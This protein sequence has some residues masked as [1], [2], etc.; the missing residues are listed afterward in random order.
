MDVKCI[1][2]NSF[3]QYMAY[4]QFF[5]YFFQKWL[6]VS[7]KRRTGPPS[8]ELC[9]Y[10]YLR[11]KKFV[12]RKIHSNDV[13]VWIGS[14]VSEFRAFPDFTLEVSRVLSQRQ[15][16]SLFLRHK[17]LPHDSLRRSDNHLFQTGKEGYVLF[18]HLLIDYI[19]NF[20]GPSRPV[21]PPYRGRHGPCYCGW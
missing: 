10:Q 12:V 18:S 5:S 14:V 11:H 13:K 20:E 9:Q 16:P 4:F 8:C 7:S 21:H 19:L 6:E 17:R 15:D 2:R 3:K 1:W